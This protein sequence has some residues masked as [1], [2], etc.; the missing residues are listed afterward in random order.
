MLTLCVLEIALGAV[1]F[2]T[3][4]PQR[5][6]SARTAC[7]SRYIIISC[8]VA[9]LC[10]G[11]SMFTTQCGTTPR[12]IMAF[13]WPTERGKLSRIHPQLSFCSLESRHCMMPLV[14]PSDWAA[15]EVAPA[16]HVT[17][18]HGGKRW[19]HAPQEVVSCGDFGNCAS[20][21]DRVSS[22]SNT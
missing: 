6:S 14:M 16:Q 2:M 18:L 22:E 1:T 9:S 15:A 20:R 21:D 17:N 5:C 3:V 7:R 8:P 12:C 4:M 10:R 19:S 13:S 11:S